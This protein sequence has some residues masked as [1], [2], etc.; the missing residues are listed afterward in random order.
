MATS[1]RIHGLWLAV[2]ALTGL[3]LSSPAMSLAQDPLPYASLKTYVQDLKATIPGRGTN[4]FIQ[5]LPEEIDAF[6]STMQQLLMG[7]LASA[8]PA[9][10]ALNY[11]LG[12]LN[13]DSGKSYWVAQERPTGFR[14]LGTYIVD[15]NYTRNVVVEVP[16]P[17]WDTNT[18]EEGSDIFQG[19]GARALFIAGTHRCANPD[20]PSGCSGTTTSCNTGSIPV[21]I[22]DAPHFTGNFMYAAHGAGLQLVSPPISLN[23]HG[24]ASEPVDITLSDGTRSS[25][26]ETALV[27]SLRNALLA[28]SVSVASCNWPDDGLTAQNL[29]GTTNAQGRLSNGSPEACTINAVNASGLFLHIEQHLNI[30][31]DPGLLIEALQQVLPVVEPED[32]LAGVRVSTSSKSSAWVPKRDSESCASGFKVDR[33]GGAPPFPPFRVRCSFA[34]WT[35]ARFSPLLIEPDVRLS[36]IRLSNGCHTRACAGGSR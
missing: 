12:V 9:L 22:S 5:P 20:T 14:G 7:D 21:R 10:D 3:L 15:S 13:D 28:R 19:L 30:R 11:D 35:I 23:L 33:S 34:E 25:G 36:R 27:N 17:L 32:G 6:G 4:A 26:A 18:P 1:N 24:N 31:N 8:M 29:C 2:L 16:H